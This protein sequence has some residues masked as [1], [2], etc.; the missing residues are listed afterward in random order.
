MSLM[1]LLLAGI[2]SQSFV[3]AESN[4]S[5]LEK[6]E[7][8]AKEVT[9]EL[10]DITTGLEKK[11]QSETSQSPKYNPFKIA[12]SPER[13]I[14]KQGQLVEYKLIIQDIHDPICGNEGEEVVCMGIGSYDY[15]ISYELSEDMKINLSQE[16]VSIM[17]GKSETINFYVV[18][19]RKGANSFAIEVSSGDSRAR[20]KAVLFID[21]IVQINSTQE[22]TAYFTGQ[23]FITNS[24]ETKGYLIDLKVLK[25]DSLIS[26][27]ISIEN[28]IF[29]IKGTVS[30]GNIEFD[31]FHPNSK[32]P[33]G[34]FKGTS[35]NLNNFILLKG[36]LDFEDSSFE[37]TATS[38][39]QGFFKDL[40]I[41]EA[42]EKITTTV[43]EI[44]AI[45]K[46]AN[47]EIKQEIEELKQEIYITPKEITKEKF[48][49]F[50]PN[51]WGAKQ[52][53]F[54]IIKD[55]II[56]KEKIREKESKEF[57]GFTIE[58]GSLEDEDN[59]ELNIEKTE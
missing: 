46:E 24:E 50:I 49:G 58:V 54:E 53:E 11:T 36:T 56:S 12:I 15:K 47:K 57:E 25:K 37:L 20:E 2:F 34:R 29:A 27:K 22:P 5:I 38:K 40:E 8:K 32:T 10:S 31:L 19:E 42:K 7:S 14:A 23:G 48:L 26:G 52:L 33:I 4:Q 55:S 17:E 6:A 3:S 59:I 21:G 45:K 13:Q 16:K 9:S 1:L 30:N 18:S 43:N 51:P 39:K 41:G 28:R 35:K 44:V